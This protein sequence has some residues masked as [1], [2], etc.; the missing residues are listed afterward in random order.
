[1]KKIILIIGGIIIIAILGRLSWAF[2][3]VQKNEVEMALN[4]K[5]ESI[6]KESPE[7]PRIYKNK[8]FGYRV[9]LPNSWQI[10]VAANSYIDLFKRY[11]TDTVHSEIFDNSSGETVVVKDQQKLT[12]LED[13]VIRE[14]DTWDPYRADFLMLTNISEIEQL[15]FYDS[16]KRGEKLILIDFFPNRVISIEPSNHIVDTTVVATSTP[17]KITKTITLPSGLRAEYRKYIHPVMGATVVY[18]P[19]FNNEHI[20][21]GLKI[22]SLQFMYFNDEIPEEDFIQLVESLTF[23]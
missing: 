1:M 17:K 2:W 5:N 21:K 22:N 20:Y 9:I 11:M 19:F 7:N 15:N 6:T 13:R 10:P 3:Q 23:N 14:K 4:S 16:V 12:D 8:K 18:V